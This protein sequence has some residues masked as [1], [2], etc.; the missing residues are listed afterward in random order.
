MDEK[1]FFIRSVM[2]L[3]IS[4]GNIIVAHLLQQIGMKVCGSPQLQFVLIFSHIYS[5]LVCF[6]ENVIDLLLGL[7][8]HHIG[9]IDVVPPI[10]SSSS[11]SSLQIT[12]VPALPSANFTGHT[13]C[14]SNSSNAQHSCKYN[15]LWYLIPMLMSEAIVSSSLLFFSPSN[16]RKKAVSSWILSLF[17]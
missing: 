12:T 3:E 4:M 8:R 14:L 6:L 9:P 13:G 2:P 1:L 5:S 15:T 16:G 17:N 10:T 7:H 11:I